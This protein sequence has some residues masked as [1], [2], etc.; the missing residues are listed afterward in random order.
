[1]NYQDL[2]ERIIKNFKILGAGKVAGGVLSALTLLI[3]G[4]FLGVQQFGI[5]AMIISI[6][7]ICNI[8]LSFR[9]WDTTIKFIGEDQD[10]KKRVSEL[11]GLSFSLNIFSSVISYFT[12]IF[13]ANSLIFNFFDSDVTSKN[14]ITTYAL[15]V[16]FI[17]INETID[18]ILRTFNEYKPIFK[19]NTYSNLFR[20]SIIAVTLM[21]FNFNLQNIINCFV[22]SYLFSFIIR[23][24]YLFMTLK[25]NKIKLS[26][27]HFP[28]T[29]NC[30]IFIKFMINAHVSNILNIANDKNLGVLAVG[31]LTN[32][33]YAGLYRAARAI[34]KI[35]RRLMDPVLEIIFP[36]LV[37]LYSAQ[38]FD[39]Y[40][41]IIFDSTKVIMFVSII[42]GAI[43]FIFSENIIFLF[44]GDSYIESISSL[45]ILIIAMVVHNL[46]YWVNPSILSSGNVKFLTLITFSTT[47]VYCISLPYSINMINHD[48][49]AIS[50][51][52]KNTL[53][54]IL[55]IIFY[56][57]FLKNKV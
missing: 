57:K 12:I 16:F 24:S 11:I 7:E 43:I 20:L 23:I 50:L 21:K 55:G 33:Y 38:Q 8:V 49:A 54:L 56:Q 40:R 37:K 15:V 47:I 4:R 41:K 9:V 22:L 19:I 30:L 36:E 35:I 3:V 28:S 45:K 46:A 53:T 39:T 14:L 2:T 48:G 52:I 1:M 13:L 6:V 26:F 10:N 34:V 42:T 18:G 51:L 17:S 32:P 27:L 44:F 25:L 29:K 5:F 31:Y